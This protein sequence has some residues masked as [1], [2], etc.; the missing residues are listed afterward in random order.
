MDSRQL[1]YFVAVAEHGGVTKAARAIK[2]AQPTLTQGLRA[3]ER[4]LGVE[5]FHRVGRGVALSDAGRVL[6]GPA[7][8]VGAGLGELAE[9]AQ[10]IVG[11][12]AGWVNVATNADL[13]A[14]PLAEVI[15][16]FRSLHP[17]VQVNLLDLTSSSFAELVLDAVCE[18][19]VVSPPVE[20]AGLV[21]VPLGTR[22][23]VLVLPPGSPASPG[24]V[25]LTELT[26]IPLMTGPPGGVTRVSLEERC[27]ELGI[28]L[29][30]GIETESEERLQDLVI[31]GAGAA[32]LPRRGSEAA[33]LRGAVVR[34]TDPAVEQR[35]ALVHRAGQLSPAARAFVEACREFPIA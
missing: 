12:D 3:L 32:L 1:R 4:E 28:T 27:T 24:P 2:V 34:D 10:R 13:V 30:A 5:L 23:L 25:P 21:T 8:Q 31:A 19:A 20:E 17:G 15:A 11:L 29:E 33:A 22:R 26:E 9:I 7:R 35:F 16:R 18:V 6:L 14:V